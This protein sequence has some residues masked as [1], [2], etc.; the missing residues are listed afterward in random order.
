MREKNKRKNRKL[1]KK[2][3]KGKNKDKKKSKNRRSLTLQ[4]PSIHPINN[5]QWRKKLRNN[6]K[7]QEMKIRKK[8][9]D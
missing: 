6:S 4:N 8:D 2:R 5:T 3:N 9:L 1:R 7:I